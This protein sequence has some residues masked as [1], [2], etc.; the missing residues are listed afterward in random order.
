MTNPKILKERLPEDFETIGKKLKK[1]NKNHISYYLLEPMRNDWLD[2]ENNLTSLRNIW[3]HPLSL[4]KDLY[5]ASHYYH[6]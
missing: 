6:M 2:S 5:M 4:G 3:C 1:E